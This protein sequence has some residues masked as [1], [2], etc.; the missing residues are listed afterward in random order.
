MQGQ[1]DPAATEEEL[2][3]GEKLAMQGDWE[4]YIVPCSTCHGPDN[5]GVSSV[6]P[7]LA[8]QHAGY[9]I[10]SVARLAVR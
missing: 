8:G 2:A 10:R 1:G 4:R 7:H 6:F 5:L 3:H 9:N